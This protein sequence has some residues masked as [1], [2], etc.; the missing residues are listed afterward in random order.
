MLGSGVI[1]IILQA[2]P[3]NSRNEYKKQIGLSVMVFHEPRRWMTHIKQQQQQ[4]R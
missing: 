1:H 2:C 4:Q 3:E